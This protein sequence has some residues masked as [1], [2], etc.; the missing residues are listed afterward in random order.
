MKKVTNKD[1]LDTLVYSRKDRSKILDF[2]LVFK[3]RLL[4]FILSLSSDEHDF[5]WN[6]I[7][8]VI[9]FEN[10]QKLHYEAKYEIIFCKG[11]DVV[12]SLCNIKMK[13]NSYMPYISKS[14]KKRG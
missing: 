5:D 11:K 14:K 12:Y 7:Y 6:A 8:V 9:D 4:N 1:L 2:S 13:K 10:N 3:Q